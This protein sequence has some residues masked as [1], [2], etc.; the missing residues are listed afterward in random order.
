MT[1]DNLHPTSTAQIPS[2]PSSRNQWHHEPTT[3][4]C[5]HPD[6]L[7]TN[8]FRFNGGWQLLRLGSKYVYFF[9]QVFLSTNN[10]LE[11]L[12]ITYDSFQRETSLAHTCRHRDYPSPLLQAGCATLFLVRTQSRQE[13]LRN[14]KRVVRRRADGPV[15]PLWSC[16]SQ[17]HHQLPPTSVTPGHFGTP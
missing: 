5:H 2:S 10:Y 4:P 3:S 12:F 16:T 7:Q 13:L 6:Y 9:L 1:W 11:S 8:H 15:R 14:W 17:L